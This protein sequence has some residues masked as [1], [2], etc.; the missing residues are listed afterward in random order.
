MLH[1]CGSAVALVS[2]FVSGIEDVETLC[3]E[4]SGVSV[5]PGAVFPLHGQL[6]SADAK[7]R[8]CEP[9]PLPRVIVA[10]NIAEE[11]ITISDVDVVVDMGC[12]RCSEDEPPFTRTSVQRITPSEATQRAGR[13]GRCKP[14]L[15]LLLGEPPEVRP[16][17][18]S[19][20]G[21][22]VLT[23]LDPTGASVASSSF[24][25]SVPLDVLSARRSS[26]LE[27]FSGSQQT[28]LGSFVKFPCSLQ[29]ASVLAAAGRC[30]ILTLLSALIVAHCTAQSWPRRAEG[31]HPRFSQ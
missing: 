17:S 8:A 16:L 5:P 28:A 9:S 18:V 23:L 1:P 24:C 31:G 22:D 21:I 26:M 3:K 19:S 4:L 13:V 10:T 15:Y 7:R 12:S 6:S 11:G 30:P 27:L 20:E 14:G 25:C 29:H 2:F